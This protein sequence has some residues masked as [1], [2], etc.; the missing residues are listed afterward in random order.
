MISHLATASNQATNKW[1]NVSVYAILK[2]RINLIRN[3]TLLNV[4]QE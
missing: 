2:K 1:Q 3:N 4:T